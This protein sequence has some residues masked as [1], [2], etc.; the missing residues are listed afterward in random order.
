MR[1][2][3]Y[4]IPIDDGA[5]PNPYWGKCTLV[6]CKPRIRSVA[7]KG[8]WVVVLGGKNVNVTD[9]S[10]K[11]VYAMKITKMM[12][13]SEY[14]EYCRNYLPNKIP[15][16]NDHDYRRKV[17]D[18]IY[19]FRSNLAGDLRPSVHNEENRSTDLSGIN[20]L[21]S[22]HFYYFGK[23]AISLDKSISSIIIQGQSHKSDKNELYKV[24]F[25][26][27]IE[28]I[29]Y[30]LNSIN[31]EP[32]IKLGFLKNTQSGEICASIRCKSAEKEEESDQGHITL[33]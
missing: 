19:N 27:W 23:N 6:I 26:E 9:Y 18:C 28:N 8:D 16:L 14:D 24:R 29:G 5:A 17:G 3:S 31:G 11:V 21:V 22:D 12:T 4:C 30:V 1:L 25:V 15:D 10:G 20:A 2:F 7:R 13:M 32:Q 33:C